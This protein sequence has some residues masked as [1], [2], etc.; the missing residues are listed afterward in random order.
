[1]AVAVLVTAELVQ[2]AAVMVVSEMQ[3]TQLLELPT[4]VA[5]EAEPQ[6][7][8]DVIP[9]KERMAVQVLLF[10]LTQLRLVL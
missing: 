3:T 2:A 10:L 5:V 4:Q 9:C 1:V 8:E 6:K 7:A